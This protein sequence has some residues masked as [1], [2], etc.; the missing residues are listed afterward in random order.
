MYS[1][2][3]RQRVVFTQGDLEMALPDTCVCCCQRCIGALMHA[4]CEAESRISCPGGS[5]RNR[6]SSRCEDIVLGIRMHLTTGG[7]A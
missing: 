4:G 1:M 2:Y 5:L 6:H 7:V 3:S